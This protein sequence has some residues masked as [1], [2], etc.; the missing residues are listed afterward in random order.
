MSDPHT[1]HNNKMFLTSRIAVKTS[2]TMSNTRVVGALIHHSTL[3]S[4]GSGLCH[5]T[6]HRCNSIYTQ[7]SEIRKNIVIQD[8]TT[9]SPLSSCC[10]HILRYMIHAHRELV[11]QLYK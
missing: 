4:V 6:R 2:I 1:A 10:G 3:S 5:T 8:A 7:Q 11:V 9:T